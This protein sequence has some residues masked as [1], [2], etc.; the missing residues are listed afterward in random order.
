LIHSRKDGNR[1]YLSANEEHP[2]YNDLV[3]LV[4][5]TDGLANMFSR[6]LDNSSID[7][8]FIFGSVARG[9]EQPAS[10]VDLFV[11]GEIGLRKLTQLLSGLAAEVGREINPHIL[12]NEEFVR[13]RRKGDHFVKS[14]LASPKLFV[15]G[16]ERELEAVGQ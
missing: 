9:N 8:A 5:K 15:K 4:R 7:V 2:V 16:S 13:R 14:V 3:S 11:V 1:I 6:A 10:D 12:T